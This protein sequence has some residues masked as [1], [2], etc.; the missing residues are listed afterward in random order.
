MLPFM[1]TNIRFDEKMISKFGGINITDGS[2]PGDL[3]KSTNM[4]AKTFPSL[5]AR[6]PRSL[7]GRCDGT[8]NGLGSFGGFIYTYHNPETK[9]IFL[10]YQGVDYEYT[11]Y[12]LSD[13]FDAPRKFAALS[14]CI[15]IIPDNVIFYSNSRS[16]SKICVSQIF[17][18]STVKEKF[19]TESGGSTLLDSAQIEY[20]ATLKHNKIICRSV[21][22]NSSGTK[23]FYYSSFD[24]SLKKGDVITLKMTVVIINY[25]DYDAYSAYRRKMREGITLKI[26]DFKTVD[27][28]VAS[29]TITE[30]V[31]LEFDNNS[32]DMGDYRSVMVESFQIDRGMPSLSGIC[33]FNNRIWGICGNEIY[34]SKLGDPSEWND[35]TSDSYGTMPYACYTT[36][37][38][39][40]G[41]FTA[42]TSYGNYI[43]AFKEN[44]IHKVY[45][46]SPDEYTLYTEKCI[47][48]DKD[49]EMCVCA[50]VDGIMF[51]SGD[52]IYCL[53]Q[54]TPKKISDTLIIDEHCMCASANESEYYILVQGNEGKFF[55]VYD[56]QRKIWHTQNA[57]ESSLFLTSADNKIYLAAGSQIICL[58]GDETDNEYEKSVS[59]SF[60]IRFDDSQIQ[61][62]GF[63]QLSMKYSLG[64]DAFFTVRAIYDDNTRGAVNGAKYDEASSYGYKINMP[65]RRCNWF[66]LE[67]CGMGNF[68]LKSMNIKFYR[69]S[70]I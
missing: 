11:Q 13:D 54:G 17:N 50:C 20:T 24:T 3:Y 63:G 33:S 45:G 25:D 21:N 42:V 68:K 41:N 34:T 40:E 49:S 62:L 30:T 6:N 10:N 28:T 64:K 35:Y 4:S 52:G 22:Y 51:A 31:E 27:H 8:I 47:G 58:S 7:V 43:Y 19:R 39:T 60:R 16:F 18:S 65:V 38:Q 15:L 36:A 14:D 12:T 55:Y 32:I 46:N 9:K 59:W 66:E 2:K 26:K 56:I 48:T 61:K 1:N 29:G 70:E 44:V 5:S 37:S 69:G 57:P 53:T 67:F 23:T